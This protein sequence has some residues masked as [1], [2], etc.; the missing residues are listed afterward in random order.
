MVKL[1]IS[2][3]SVEEAMESISGGADIIDIKNPL[4]GSLGANFPWVIREIAKL[5]KKHSKEVSATIGDMDFKPGTASLAAL[6]AAHSGVDYIKVGL[7]RIKNEEEAYE[8]LKAVLRAVKDLDEKKKVIAA[9]YAD[10]RNLGSISPLLLPEVGERAG[11][12]GVMVDTALKDGKTLFDHMT[13]NEIGKFVY[14]SKMRGLLCAL[15]G[16]ITWKHL[17]GIKA[18][19]PDII[20]VRTLVCKNG[21]NSDI[22]RGLVDRLANMLKQ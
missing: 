15:A 18:L 22:D 10:Y 4:E 20:G 7:F 21:R 2:P 19:R 8:M 5:S 16:G 12:D 3:M 17:K 11:V 1:L 6:G 14:E 13:S 9:A